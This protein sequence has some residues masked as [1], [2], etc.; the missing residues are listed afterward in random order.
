MVRRKIFALTLAMV[1]S[2]SL[3]TSCGSKEENAKT[4]PVS[5]QETTKTESEASEE[6]AVSETVSEVSEVVSEDE[7]P[8]LPF[9]VHVSSS[10]RNDKTGNW[11]AA[12]YAG[13]EVM[14]DYAAEYY[15]T[16]FKDD[17]EL[18]FVWNASLKTV[19]KIAKYGNELD[20]ATYEY[21]KGE[22]HDAA[23]AC[24][25]QLYGEFYLNLDTG[26]VTEIQ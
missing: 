24:T 5:Q 8:V 2:A 16:Y 26:E 3:I 25:G 23:M 18:H 13:S 15:Y 1:L 14:S 7:H 19:T 6:P 11:R 4:E 21:V 20:V 12:S 10:Y 22:E 9:D 17:S